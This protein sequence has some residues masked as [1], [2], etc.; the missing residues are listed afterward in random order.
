MTYLI[1]LDFESHSE[2]PIMQSTVEEP[3]YNFLKAYSIRHNNDMLR[4]SQG[5]AIEKR[6]HVMIILSQ[7]YMLL[8]CFSPF[9]FMSLS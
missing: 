5:H 4:F 2:M 3:R 8:Q 1:C 7:K 9:K 6:S